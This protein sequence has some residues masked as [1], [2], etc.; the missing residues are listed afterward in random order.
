M[1]VGGSDA[2]S[3]NDL[4]GLNDSGGLSDSAQES[5]GVAGSIVGRS[6]KRLRKKN[7]PTEVGEG[8]LVQHVVGVTL[9]NLCLCVL[10]Y[11]TLTLLLLLFFNRSRW[12][13][14]DQ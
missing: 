3:G 1:Q 6:L 11:K 4:G 14:I 5:A 9:Q 12:L 8:R 10:Q 2:N 7:H 13:R